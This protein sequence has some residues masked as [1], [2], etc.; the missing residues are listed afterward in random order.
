MKKFIRELRRR[1]VFRTAGLYIGIGWILIEAVSVVGPIFDVPDWILQFLVIAVMVGFP[2]MLV[3]AWVYDVSDKG[4]IVQ[5]DATDTVVIPFGGRKADFSVIGV[6][7]V[8]LILSVYLNITSGPEII[9]ELE[10]VSILIADF[11]NQTGDPLFNGA[12]E[13]AL[14]IG[15]EG[16]PFVS[17]YA[18]GVA[19]KIAADIRNSNVLDSAAAQLVAVREGI[20]LV[21][22]G[23]IIP[24]DDEFELVIRAIAPRSGEVVIEVDATS[25]SKLEV[26]ATIGELAA[27]IRE[28]LGD[29]SLDRE[30]LRIS[31][32]FT[33]MSLHAA[34]EYDTAQNLQYEGKY[35]QAIELS[36]S[37]RASS[38]LSAAM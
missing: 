34:R 17:V 31:E 9:E 22:A 12:L 3:L 35:E 16:A 4:V 38:V 19:K 25:P 7:A 29:K 28:A 2:V 14:Q 36:A 13:Q 23:S 37:F 33:A 15:V 26:L 18:R 32:T 8:A 24:D 1:E 30:A 10:P 21:L 11:D 20:K 27:D 5:A 6:L